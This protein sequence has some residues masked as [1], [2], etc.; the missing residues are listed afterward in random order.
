MSIRLKQVEDKS[1]YFKVRIL[2]GEN[3][4]ERYEKVKIRYYI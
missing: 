3:F 1:V 4:S 2:Q